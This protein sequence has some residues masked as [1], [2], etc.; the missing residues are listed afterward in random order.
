VYLPLFF[1]F[2]GLGF[3][4]EH[5][6]SA[7]KKLKITSVCFAVSA[8]NPWLSFI[9]K[10]R[11]LQEDFSL[12]LKAQKGICCIFSAFFENPRKN[13]RKTV[14]KQSIMDFILQREET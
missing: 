6:E 12:G 8:V 5:A 9:L 11:I 3:T 7:E 13:K 4:A 2:L 10:K 1:S 14:T